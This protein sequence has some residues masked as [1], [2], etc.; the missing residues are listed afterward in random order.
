M[1]NNEPQMN[2]HDVTDRAVDVL[3]AEPVW[4]AL[5]SFLVGVD[6][7]GE[8]R[9]AVVDFALTQL[10]EFTDETVELDDVDWDCVTAYF[11]PE[12]YA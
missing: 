9:Y 4:S 7:W 2:N 8:T 3:T 11:M 5:N 12:D 1:N 10:S 6:G